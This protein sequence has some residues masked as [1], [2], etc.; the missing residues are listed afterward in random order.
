M[1]DRDVF[2]GLVSV[3][4]GLYVLAGALFGH[5]RMLEARLPGM[6]ARQFGAFTARCLLVATGTLFIVLGLFL[7]RPLFGMQSSSSFWHEPR[8]AGPVQDPGPA[9][10]LAKLETVSP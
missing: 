5:E 10:A 1:I 4:A 7:L 6:L 2:V 9:I 3:G 8:N